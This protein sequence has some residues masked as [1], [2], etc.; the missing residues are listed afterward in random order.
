MAASSKMANKMASSNKEK[1]RFSG[2]WVI[3]F[4]VAGI[5]ILGDL[6]RRMADARRLDRD[7]R[8]L[9]TEVAH[10]ATESGI[11]Q[12]KVAEVTSESLV[13]EWAHGEGGMVREGEI[14]VAP[15]APL[16]VTP[17]ATPTPTP[18]LREPSN[19]EVWWALLFGG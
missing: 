12:T 6:N 19:W 18:S 2:M 13:G 5:L 14:L 4:I 9:E 17:V 8:A 3:I 11:L 1:Q 10:L 7:A 15:I 16:E